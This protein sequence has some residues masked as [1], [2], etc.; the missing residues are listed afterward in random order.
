MYRY[1]CGIKWYV[2]PIIGINVIFTAI[3][4]T[5]SAKLESFDAI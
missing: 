5:F 3:H 1:L 2:D 4:S